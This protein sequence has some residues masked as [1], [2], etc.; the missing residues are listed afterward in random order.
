MQLPTETVYEVLLHSS[1]KEVLK[2][3]M[4][5]KDSIRFA[6]VRNFGRYMLKNGFG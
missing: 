1:L 6:P 2:N 3:V 4:S 5:T